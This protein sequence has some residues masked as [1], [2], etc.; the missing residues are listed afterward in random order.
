MRRERSSERLEALTAAVALEGYA[1]T[2]ADR[3]ADHETAIGSDGHAGSFLGTVPALPDIRI[4]AAFLKR[5]RAEIAN[6]LA[7]FPQ[8]VKQ[9]EQAA[10]FWWDVVGDM[11]CA[12]NEAV[13]Q[14]ASVGLDALQLAQ[15]LRVKFELPCRDLVFGEYNVMETLQKHAKE[16]SG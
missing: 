16:G 3:V 4:V 14:T 6:Q 11:E 15:S 5:E 13:A 7:L 1:L 2:C 8:E 10:S 9:A 12:R